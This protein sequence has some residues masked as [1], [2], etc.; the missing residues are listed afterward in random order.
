MSLTDS[1]KDQYYELIERLCVLSDAVIDEFLTDL[2]EECEA[3]GGTWDSVS[4]VVIARSHIN[5]WHEETV[6]EA[7]STLDDNPLEEQSPAD[8]DSEDDLFGMYLKIRSPFYAYGTTVYLD[9]NGVPEGE[10]YSALPAAYEEITS[11]DV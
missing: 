5:P 10:T 6:L 8:F 2:R 3:N 4:R 1:Q 7:L 11:F 9:G